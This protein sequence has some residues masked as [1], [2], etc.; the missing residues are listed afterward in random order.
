MA[1][2]TADAR[3]TQ[4]SDTLTPM[5]R[6]ASATLAFVVACGGNGTTGTDSDSFEIRNL[7]G[8]GA[9]TLPTIRQALR[10]DEQGHG[11]A[12]CLAFSTTN[13]ERHDVTVTVCPANQADGCMTVRVPRSR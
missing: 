3:V 6:A 2:Q 8:A 1:R 13:Y 4:G 10:T 7:T 12:F 9:A 5:K 11:T